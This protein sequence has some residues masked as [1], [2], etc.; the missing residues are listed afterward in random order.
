M[1]LRS[2]YTIFVGM[3]L[4]AVTNLA[5]AA[6]NWREPYR[7]A[8]QRLESQSV[9]SS[10]ALE[11]ARQLLSEARDSLSQ[12]TPDEKAEATPYLQYTEGLISLYSGDLQK[13]SDE[14][15]AVYDTSNDL[16]AR[17]RYNLAAINLG[18][19]I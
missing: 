11:E 17:A 18:K 3:L 16:T 14:F 9:P 8:V 15:L 5:T 7:E 10:A 4:F 13:A 6:G 2:F 19:A 12:A 1:S